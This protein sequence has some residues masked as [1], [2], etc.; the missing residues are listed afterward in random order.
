MKLGT[1][2]T[3][4]ETVLSDEGNARKYQRVIRSRKSKKNIQYNGQTKID[5]RTNNDNTL[6]TKHQAT[7]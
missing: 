6:K 5:K 3:Y 4:I 7:L 2:L 1:Q